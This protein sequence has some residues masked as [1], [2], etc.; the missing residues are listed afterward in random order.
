M[1]HWL[2]HV[3]TSS[4]VQISLASQ[5]TKGEPLTEQQYLHVYI[6]CKYDHCW[7]ELQ[8]HY[9]SFIIKTEHHFMSNVQMFCR[10]VFSSAAA[11]WTASISHASSS[12]YWLHLILYALVL[13]TDCFK[14]V[15]SIT[16]N[17]VHQIAIG[18]KKCLTL[19]ICLTG[20]DI[21]TPCI[22]IKHII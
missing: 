18:W 21:L 4:L 10:T 12:C 11:S 22:T 15:C 9:Y 5:F 7:W 19:R 1:N 2:C 6:T 13:G 16:K 20:G 17:L 14:L 3:C 8:L